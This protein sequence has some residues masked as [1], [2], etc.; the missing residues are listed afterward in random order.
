MVRLVLSDGMRLGVIGVGVGM[1]GAFFSTK[2][3]ESM[4]FGVERF[5]PMV[6]AGVSG[7][8]L[9]MAAAGGILP[10]RRAARVD[11]LETLKAEG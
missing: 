1:V 5:D 10:A 7:L 2:V 3:L 9:L 11:P 8:A 4:L 6:L